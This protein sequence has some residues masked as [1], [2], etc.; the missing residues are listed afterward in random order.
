MRKSS[1]SF[2]GLPLQANGFLHHQN[3]SSRTNKK[4]NR[5]M[6]LLELLIV[7]SLL[8]IVALASVSLIVDTGEYK[9]QEVTEDK[10]LSIKRAILGDDSVDASGRRDYAGFATDMGRLP[11]CL[12]ELIR[13]YDCEAVLPDDQN[14][15]DRKLSIYS[16]EID[17]NQWS[18]WRGPYLSIPGANEYRD[19]WGNIGIGY[20]KDNENSKSNNEINYGWLFGT[21]AANGTLCEEAVVTQ[22]QPGAVIIQSCG[23][24]G[25]V[26]NTTSDVFFDDYPYVTIDG[27]GNPIYIPTATRHDYQ[28]EMGAGWNEVPVK[29]KSTEITGRSR[30]IKANDLRLRLNYPIANGS[31][32]DWED[33]FITEGK[34]PD[35]AP[36]LSATFPEVDIRMV[37]AAGKVYTHAVSGTLT[38]DSSG[39]KK[40]T[41]TPAVT[42]IS[43]AAS[44][45]LVEIA[46][47]IPSTLTFDDV[48]DSV[49]MLDCPCQFLVEPAIAVSGGLTDG[50]LISETTNIEVITINSGK[51]A[52]LTAELGK[53]MIEVPQSA[54]VKSPTEVEL[55][56]GATLN[57]SNPGIESRYFPKLVSAE[58]FTVTVDGF[59]VSAI[60]GDLVTIDN[61]DQ[62]IIPSIS[63]PPPVDNVITIAKTAPTI[64]KGLRSI[65]IVC[66]ADGFLFDGNCAD[67]TVGTPAVY[68]P[69]ATPHKL[70]VSP[71]SY[72]P[73]PDEIIW[74]LQ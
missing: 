31:I 19:G 2:A 42:V 11:N 29:I 1:E 73:R 22:Q 50:D 57:I 68:S 33:L 51:I 23:D 5:G 45:T 17:S 56:N 30:V 66:E 6:T 28:V 12:R 27:D 58:S 63:P 34:D 53:Y 49:L 20:E 54:D 32:P 60:E 55:P 13:P 10:W 21:G 35:Q 39:P 9:Q 62:F 16:Q 44:S 14:D 69:I 24:G 15:P 3:H 26:G 74:N 43:T 4:N 7:V 67:N 25:K 46:N 71:R 52:P 37:D 41:F 65:T 36:F 18:G 38:D 64:P 48:V 61:G 8:G 40:V 70:N 47:D 72:I 59:N